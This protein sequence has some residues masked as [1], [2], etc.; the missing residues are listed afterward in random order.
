MC[1][2][3]CPCGL[4]Y[5]HVYG[6]VYEHAYRDVKDMHTHVIDMF[7]DMFMDMCKDMC[8]DMSIDMCNEDVHGRAYWHRYRRMD[9]HVYSHNSATSH[10]IVDLCHGLSRRSLR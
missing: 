1:L 2:Y 8:I 3:T 10:H 5:R 7:I 4:L 9:R 6:H